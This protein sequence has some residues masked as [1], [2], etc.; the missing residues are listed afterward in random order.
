M[1]ARIYVDTSVLGVLGVMAAVGGSRVNG[2]R[3]CDSL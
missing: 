3:R 1:T 2:P